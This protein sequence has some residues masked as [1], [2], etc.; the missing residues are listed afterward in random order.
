M[1]C[2][3]VALLAV[4]CGDGAAAPDD[5]EVRTVSCEVSHAAG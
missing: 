1:G 3:V 2:A 4:A 5:A